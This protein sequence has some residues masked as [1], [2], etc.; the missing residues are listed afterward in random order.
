MI[1]V[2]LAAGRG[3]RIGSKGNLKPKSLLKIYKKKTILDYQI[4]IL[5]NLQAKKI[6]I[7]VGYKM[8][9]IKKNINKNNIFF[10]ENKNWRKTNVLY[11]FSLCLKYIKDDF[12]FM[13]ADSVAEESIFKRIVNFRKTTLPIYVKKCGDEEMKLF[14]V[15]EE[16]Y[17]S[18][19][20]PINQKPAGEFMGVAYFKKDSIS[21]FIKII[22]NL[23]KDK[24]FN[25]FF[26][27]QAINELAK[28]HKIKIVKMRKVKFAEIDFYKDYIYVK[29]NFKN[30]F[31]KFFKQSYY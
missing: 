2:I 5:E 19:N 21:K 18:K 30:Y 27:E 11:S 29:K 3:S 12:I 7:I 1:G 28:A 8:N 31:N 13:H 6:F 4:K 24:Y 25:T 17:L 20:T 22:K 9:I 14:K 16:M 26:F 23:K 10:I 15:N